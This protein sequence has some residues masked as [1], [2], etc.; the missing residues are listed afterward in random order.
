MRVPSFRRFASN[1]VIAV[2]L[3]L[4]KFCWLSI[5]RYLGFPM[6]IRACRYAVSNSDVLLTAIDT[7]AFVSLATRL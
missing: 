2:G 1:S 3:L 6:R 4:T 7:S 5:R